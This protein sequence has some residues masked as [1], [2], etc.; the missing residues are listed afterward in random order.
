V[1]LIDLSRTTGFRLA[2][3]FV[4]VFGAVQLLLFGYL[5]VQITGF[6]R[7][8]ID[9]WLLRE[10]TSL[11][12][13]QP[14]D[15][16]AVIK[17]HT[18]IDSVGR[19]PFALFDADGRRIAGGYPGDQPP[20]PRFGQPFATRIAAPGRPRGNP[21]RCIAERVGG[22]MVTLQCQITR[23]LDHFDE[24][25]LHALLV[26]GLAMLAIGIASAIALGSAAVRRLDQ[27]TASIKVV[28]A[29]DLTGRL[30]LS[31]TKDEMGR[32]TMVVNRMLDDI[33]RL[34]H[35]VKGVCDAIAHDLRTPMTRL[36]ASLERAQRRT[37]STSEYRA[38]IDDAVD[39][40]QG[41]LRTF[42][43]LLRISEIESSARAS[44]FHEVDL[45]AVM[46]DVV[47]LYEPIAEQK[48][49]ALAYRRSG[50]ESLQM[51]GDPNLL[52]EA[53]G[54]LLENAIKFTPYGGHVSIEPFREE[55]VFGI[56]I[57]DTGP[58]IP[59]EDRQ[60]VFRRFYRAEASRNA[61]GTG[62]GLSLAY[63]IATMHDMA[64]E[65]LDAPAGCTVQLV[66]RE[67]V[68]SGVEPA[69]PT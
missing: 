34:M 35:E 26:A 38:V 29:G 24:E 3:I 43:S 41:L 19:F 28:M 13:Q 30:P 62:L 57:A 15:F 49:I 4:A 16:A 51:R 63:A 46:D 22:G 52:F 32:L 54:N 12:R 48:R 25:L 33:E 68:L 69:E 58:G 11:L 7:E 67:L 9:D 6:D 20:I 65:I 39:E 8:R 60:A 18:A 45:A 31:S 37:L 55:L 66:R 50:S 17:R 10:R 64:L 42:K 36:L 1:R 2:A 47:E 23:D 40:L 21:A 27:L 14:E 53:L 5:Y 59:V 56:R 44:S 61:P